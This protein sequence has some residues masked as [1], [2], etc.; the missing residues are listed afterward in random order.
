MN[1]K[2]SEAAKKAWATRR[3]NEA[4]QARSEKMRQAARKAWDTRRRDEEQ[5]EAERQEALRI[6]EKMGKE[7]NTMADDVAAVCAEFKE[8][9][10]AAS[11]GALAGRA[12][13]AWERMKRAPNATEARRLAEEFL[14]SLADKKDTP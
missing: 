4:A 12:V 6:L 1:N 13:L 14:A 7:C 3:R 9:F 8:R 5:A 2:K 10:Q 11:Q